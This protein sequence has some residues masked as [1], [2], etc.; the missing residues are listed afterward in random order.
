MPVGP[1]RGSDTSG[2]GG[3]SDDEFTTPST[4]FFNQVQAGVFTLVTSVI[5]FSGQIPWVRGLWL[6]GSIASLK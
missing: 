2:F 6:P 5:A 3:L 4:A 1:L